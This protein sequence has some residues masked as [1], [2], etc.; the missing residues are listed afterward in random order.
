MKVILKGG[1]DKT[2]IMAVREGVCQ[3]FD[4]GAWLDLRVGF[5]MSI[6]G[7]VDPTDDDTITGLSE[8]LIG[9][10]VTDHCFI[11]VRNNGTTFPGTPGVVFAGFVN[12][13]SILPVAASK[14]VT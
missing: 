1:V 7:D 5:L 3:P 12:G 2:V 13:A 9:P 11:G 8:T 14:L 4:A 6:C 10:A